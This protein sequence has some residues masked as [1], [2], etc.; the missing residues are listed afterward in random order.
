MSAQTSYRFSTQMGAAGGIMD[1]APYAI[2]TFLNEEPH[3]KMLFGLGVVQGTAPG[4][5]VKLPAA[6]T[7]KF[8]GVVTNRRTTEY[9]LEGRIYI[10]HGVSLGI[11]RYG[12]IYVR[13]DDGENLEENTVQY[14]ETPYVI[15]KGDKAGYFT[16]KAEGNLEV[17]GRF[18]TG[19]DNG[20]AGVELFNPNFIKADP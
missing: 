10:R 13:L 2:D 6:S 5:D 8:E 11:M 12:R 19:P 17:A 20:I 16:N 1:L 18:V 9:D 4:N 15:C 14:G 7:D 3:G